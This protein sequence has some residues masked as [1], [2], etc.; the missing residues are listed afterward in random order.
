MHE[1]LCVRTTEQLHVLIHTPLG[2]G[3]CDAETITLESGQVNWP[4]TRAGSD[5]VIQPCP[6]NTNRT[7]TRECTI[8]AIWTEADYDTCRSFDSIQE[9]LVS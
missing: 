1:P 6:G 8:N 9:Q 5:P 7:V 2:N 3:F 4:E